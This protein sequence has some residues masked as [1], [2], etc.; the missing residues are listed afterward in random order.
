MAAGRGGREREAGRVGGERE[1]DGRR[2]E[3]EREPAG[4]AEQA[5]FLSLPVFVYFRIFSTTREGFD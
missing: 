1:R 2:K 5:V 4:K 3:G